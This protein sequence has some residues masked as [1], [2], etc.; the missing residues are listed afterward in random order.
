MKKHETLQMIHATVFSLSHVE[1]EGKL[2][3]IG[4]HNG[5]FYSIFKNNSFSC[6]FNILA[7]TVTNYCYSML[8]FLHTILL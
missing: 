4:K 5:N 3:A 7:K 6:F 8:Y 2:M 1:R